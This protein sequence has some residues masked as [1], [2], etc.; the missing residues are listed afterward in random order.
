LRIAQHEDRDDV[1]VL[2]MD[3][4]TGVGPDTAQ[5]IAEF[6]TIQRSA[7]EAALHLAQGVLSYPREYAKNRL[8]WLAD[9]VR[10][11]CDISL[12]AATTGSGS[13]RGGLH[14]ELLL[15]RA[16]VEASIGWDFGP[17]SIVED[18]QFAM[19]FC[20]RHRGRSGWFAALSYG[21]SP[22][23]VADFVRQRERWVW[24]L[25]ELAFKSAIPLRR[26]MLLLHN[27]VVWAFGPV[28]HPA[29][30]LTL[31]MIVSDPGT[32]P[33]TV[34]LVPLWT[35]NVSYLVWVYWEGLKINA[36][37]S[38]HSRRLWWE[39]V[40]LVALLPVFSLWE[41]LGV[42]RGLVRFILNRESIFTVIAKPV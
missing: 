12:F 42:L 14:G 36:A 7:G 13:P 33:A 16:S 28:Q 3:D 19:H 9:A 11:G 4:D 21:A 15:I 38:R 5:A 34:L 2:H 27:V 22:A 30:V 37:A 41:V 6:I 26:R 1:W 25:L 32:A 18:A 24:G 17:R 10:P 8:T 35:M 20:E 39:P 31:A 23:T 29:V 40:G